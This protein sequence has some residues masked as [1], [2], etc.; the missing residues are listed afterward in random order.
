M[1]ALLDAPVLEEPLDVFRAY[2]ATNARE[3]AYCHYSPALIRS[4]DQNWDARNRQL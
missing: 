3:H 1:R 2:M 4:L